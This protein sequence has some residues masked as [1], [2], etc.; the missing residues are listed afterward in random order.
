MR[1]PVVGVGALEHEVGDCCHAP[2]VGWIRGCGDLR[3]DAYAQGYRDAS[4]R[5]V[6]YISASA[7]IVAA[8]MSGAKAAQS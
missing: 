5:R 2:L 3:C 6:L 4:A 8:Y 1:R 7:P